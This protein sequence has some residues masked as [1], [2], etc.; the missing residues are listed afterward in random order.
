L[1]R[2][3]E[4]AIPT[5]VL[6]V[7]PGRA[8]LRQ[9]FY[10]RSFAIVAALV[11]MLVVTAVYGLALPVPE[12]LI[13]V[14]AMVI[15]NLYTGYRLRLP[16]QVSEAEVFR[17]LVVDLQIVTYLLYLAG[18][19]DNPFGSLFFVLLTIAS[20]Y[21]RWPYALLVT[22][23]TLGDFGLLNIQHMQLAMPDGGQVPEA[24]INTG[25]DVSYVLTGSLIAFFVLRVAAAARSYAASLAAAREQQLSDRFVVG[26][27]T[28]AAGAAHEMATPLS[29][30][31]V[32]VKELRLGRGDVSEGLDTI[33]RQVES[34]KQTLRYLSE[35]AGRS[36]AEYSDEVA[37]DRF[38]DS[39]ADRLR[40]WRPD[41]RLQ[42]H[43]DMAQP[44]PMVSG[45]PTLAQALLTLLNNAADAS[46]NEVSMTAR[47]TDD[48]L[49]LE[50]LDRGP[51]I[52]RE[53]TDRLGQPFVTTKGPAKG[54]GMGLFLAKTSIE[55]LGGTLEFSE[56]VGGGTRVSV[57]LPIAA[58]QI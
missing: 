41:A 48:M 46:Q 5:S 29:V 43:W 30:I 15:Y 50:V 26:F 49:E 19:D 12:L 56:R 14:V 53:I 35:A 39:V 32:L 7:S 22:T 31:A 3:A 33:S 52:P 25:V 18:G 38:L 24:T 9:L 13:G 54:M 27:G 36:R 34:C 4:A 55:R 58:I 21:L 11:I 42:T 40:V 47:M 20:A 23:V 10:L 2:F 1:D 44:V 37:L 17:Q 57:T 28:L 51:G 6:G 45:D 16:Q 8:T